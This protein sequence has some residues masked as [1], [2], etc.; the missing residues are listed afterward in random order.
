MVMSMFFGRC[1]RLVTN[2]TTILRPAMAMA[3]IV[4]RPITAMPAPKLLR[5]AAAA[6]AAAAAGVG[7]AI[8]AAPA[9]AFSKPNTKEQTYS[10]IPRHRCFFLLGADS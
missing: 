5:P 3:T 6:A 4:P 9:Q 7:L 2:S 1:S 10:K 8:A